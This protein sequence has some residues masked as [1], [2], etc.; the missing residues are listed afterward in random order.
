MP[1]YP[2]K[3]IPF[4]FEEWKPITELSVPGVYQ[5]AYLVSNFGRIYSNIRQRMLTSVIT[6][7]GYLRVAIGKI[8]NGKPCHN[9]VLLHRI[10]MIEFCPV[11]G[12]QNLEVNH[13]NGDKTNC[14]VYNLEWATCSENIQ[15]A[16]DTG[17]KHARKG[18][19]APNSVITLA[20]AEQVAQMII[21]RQ[22]EH[23]EI[24][25]ILGIPLH[26]I[27]NIASGS[28]WRDVYN[29]Y[30]LAEYKRQRN[31]YK[32]SDEQL[33]MLCKYFQDHKNIQYRYIADLYR[34]ALKELFG[35]EFVQNMSGSLSRIYGHKTRRDITDLYDY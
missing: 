9:Y 6:Q 30:H 7:N 20:Q 28:T 16:F 22:Y 21:T 24:A 29:K 13:R 26:I 34:N 31:D 1:I 32:F 23:K 17:L 15:H 2:Y 11:E 19:D 33:H 35:I 14:C 18:E 25:E 10:V 3:N 27:H 4:I 5:G 8:K 12:W